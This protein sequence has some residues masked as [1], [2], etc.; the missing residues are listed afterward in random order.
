MYDIHPKTYIHSS[1]FEQNISVWRPGVIHSG[2]VPQP[3]T[4]GSILSTAQDISRQCFSA[5]ETIIVGDLFGVWRTRKTSVEQRPAATNPMRVTA[6]HKLV[7]ASSKTTFWRVLTGREPRYER[8]H[9]QVFR[10]SHT[11]VSE[12]TK[13]RKGTEGIRAVSL[14]VRAAG[15]TTLICLTCARQYLLQALK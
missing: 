7:R 11:G 13:A 12:D 9:I 8:R 6:V 1:A 2:F 14:C 4:L 3:A 10:E 15:N 5:I